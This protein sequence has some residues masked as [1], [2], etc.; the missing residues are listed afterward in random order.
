MRLGYT[1]EYYF[2]WQFISLFSQTVSRDGQQRSPESG[3]TLC[4]LIHCS[5]YDVLT[6]LQEV[7]ANVFLRPADTCHIEQTRCSWLVED[8]QLKRA[9][10]NMLKTVLR[11]HNVS[12]CRVFNLKVD[13]MHFLPLLTALWKRKQWRCSNT[14]SHCRPIQLIRMAK[15]GSRLS[16]N[17]LANS[18]TCSSILSYQQNH[19]K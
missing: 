2:I 1:P 10:R 11:Y 3:S 6:M 16:C 14:S 19:Y 4:S 13:R 8:L 7:A 17:S 18:C 9:D 5:Q 15:T 12:L